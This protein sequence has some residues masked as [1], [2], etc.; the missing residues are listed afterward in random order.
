M[1]I[2]SILRGKGSDI[3]HA[4]PEQSV[5]DVVRLLCEHRIGAVLVMDGDRVAGVLSERDVVRELNVQ[6]AAV[7]D[8]K[9]RDIMTAD[10]VSVEPGE[11]ITSALSRMTRRRI[12]HLPVLAEGRVIGIVSIGDLVK[13][14][15]DQA[16]TE[17]EA[18][19]D[20]IAHA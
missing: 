16:V 6:G 4:T 1:T 14:R 5:A 15:I 12:R 11:S 7:L 19:K 9:A 2:A 3:I 8:R 13:A 18:L 10:V 20:Y 17:A